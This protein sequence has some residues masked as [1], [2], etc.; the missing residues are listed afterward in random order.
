MSPEVLNVLKTVPGV[1]F[2]WEKKRFV[3]HIREHNKLKVGLANM[4]VVVESLPSLTLAAITL[5][6]QK[7]ESSYVE[8]VR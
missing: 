1:R 6:N 4:G 7:R 3:F 5:K 8:V 2:D